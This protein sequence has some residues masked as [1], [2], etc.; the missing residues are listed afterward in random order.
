M[1]RY[2]LVSVFSGVVFGVLDGVINANALAQRLYEVYK[3]ISRESVNAPLGITIDLAYGF[4]MAGL[5]LLLCR[6]LP[7]RRGLWKGLSFGL[8]AW[9][10]RVVMSVMGSW[11][12]L[13]VPTA[14]LLYTLSTGLAE[15]L[16]LGAIYGLLLRDPQS[17][18]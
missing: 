7:G 15:M 17:A 3:P 8:I 6:S 13:R 10:F 14:A 9:F 11:V 4:V 2:L 18:Q 16:I 5:F 12:T 1:L